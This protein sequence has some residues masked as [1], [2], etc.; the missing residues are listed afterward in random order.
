MVLFVFGIFLLF[1]GF[2]EVDLFIVINVDVWDFGVGIDMVMVELIVN[3]V[4]IGMLLLGMGC[5]VNFNYSLLSVL[6]GIVIVVLCVFDFVV[7]VYSFNC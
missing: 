7:L 6:S 2:D 5:C 1:N 4:I 3:G